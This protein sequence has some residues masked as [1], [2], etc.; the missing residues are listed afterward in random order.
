M[1]GD[2]NQSNQGDF[3]YGQQD[4]NVATSDFNATAFL[5]SQMIGQLDI[6]KLVK[7]MKVTT[8]EGGAGDA[9]G[10]S[11]TVDVQ[12]LVSQIDGNGNGTPHGTVHNIPWTRQQGGK[13]AIVIDPLAGDIGYVICA[14]RDISSVKETGAVGPAPT[15]RKYN[16][17]DGVYIGG[18]LN[19]APDQYL[20]WT[21]DGIRIV[22]KHGNSYTSN[23][24]GI[25]LKPAAGLPVTIDGPLI[26][27]QLF[28]A[29]N[30]MQLAGT[31]A[32][33]GGGTYSGDVH[34]SG[35]VTGDTDVVAAGK[36]GA[37]HTHPVTTAPGN[38][39]QPA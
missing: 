1:A 8:G 17:S 12:P 19:V 18:V 22:D 20:Q 21:E 25:T 29:K 39:G 30:G 32:G 11:G 5:V 23:S 16:L 6:M 34:T 2:T 36:S 3:G 26:V 27:N 4:P 13:N 24:S 31:I 35:T 7:V 37:H 38:T 15:R 10:K 28:T 9:P 14:D 33:I